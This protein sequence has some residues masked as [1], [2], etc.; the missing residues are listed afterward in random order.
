MDDPPASVFVTGANGFMGRA[1]T[2]RYRSAGVDVAGV[3]VT[4]DPDRGVIAG[5]VLDPSGWADAI[6]PGAVVIHTAAIVR[7][8]MPR[9]VPTANATR[10][11]RTDA[12]TRF[13]SAKGELGGMRS[14]VTMP[15]VFQ[16]P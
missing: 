8:A 9:S 15:S 11:T 6:A 10:G 4:A 7:G 14:S 13:V 12:I 3:D 5:D 16:N 2:E 1:L